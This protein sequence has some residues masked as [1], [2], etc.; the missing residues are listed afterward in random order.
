MTKQRTYAAPAAEARNNEAL[1][2][3]LKEHLT[4]R[5]VRMFGL[6]IVDAREETPTL[7]VTALV[8]GLGAAFAT[9]LLFVLVGFLATQGLPDGGLVTAAGTAVIS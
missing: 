3:Y 1:L 2:A 4:Q 6:D 8:S 7:P 9:T 5:E